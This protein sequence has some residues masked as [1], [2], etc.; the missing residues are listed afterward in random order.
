MLRTH[1]GKRNPYW[2]S[3]SGLPKPAPR[4]YKGKRTPAARSLSGLWCSVHVDQKPES[5]KF[6]LEDLDAF[7]ERPRDRELFKLPP[8]EVS[9]DDR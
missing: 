2:K 4:P 1:N 8:K 9:N 6:L 7:L 3:R 5:K